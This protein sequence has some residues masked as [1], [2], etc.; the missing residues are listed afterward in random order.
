M[1]FFYHFFT[2]EDVSD[3]DPTVRAKSIILFIRV[4]LSINMAEVERS[5]FIPSQ[6]YYRC[7][8]MTGK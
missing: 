1:D 5:L 4:V 2:V 7:A 6:Q 8:T 3:C